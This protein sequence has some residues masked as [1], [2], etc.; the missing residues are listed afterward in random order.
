M[1][2]RSRDNDVKVYTQCSD[3]K[4]ADVGECTVKAY[5]N[6]KK[7]WRGNKRDTTSIFMFATWRHQKRESCLSMPFQSQSWDTRHSSSGP[8]Q[9]IFQFFSYTVCV[10]I[11]TFH[12]HFFFLQKNSTDLNISILYWFWVYNR[13]YP[14]TSFKD[15]SINFIN[16]LLYMDGLLL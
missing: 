7:R 14:I 8:G 4:N 10:Q 1:L 11:L 5:H 2:D 13:Y 16:A 3:V 15:L 6:K 9:I 12:V